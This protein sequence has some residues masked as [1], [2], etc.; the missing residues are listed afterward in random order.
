[1]RSSFL[2]VVIAVSACSPPAQSGPPPSP[3]KEG[4]SKSED[5]QPAHGAVT[6]ETP[7]GAQRYAVELAIKPLER[8][9]GLMYREHLD[10]DAGM[11]F[12]FEDMR[13]QSFWMK[14]TRIPL[15]MIFIDDDFVIAGIVESA[16]PLTLTSRKVDKKSRYVL[17][18]AGGVSRKRGIARGQ[19]VTF[20]GV[21]SHLIQKGTTP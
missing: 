9:K 13:I 7:T 17:E 14:N 19:K 11:L 21:P 18:L 20:E 5:M 15:D 10:D 8:N 4:A 16:E 6:I 2:V 12:I 3:S 1:M